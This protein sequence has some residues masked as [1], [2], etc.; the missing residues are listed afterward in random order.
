MKKHAIG[1]LSESVKAQIYGDKN[2]QSTSTTASSSSIYTTG[3]SSRAFT[4]TASVPQTAASADLK[5]LDELELR[6]SV[7]ALVRK[8]KMKGYVEMITNKGSFKVQLH[9][10]IAPV[11]CDNFLQLAESK[12]YDGVKFHRLIS[13]FMMQG[14]DPTGTGRGGKSAFNNGA[15]FKDEFDSRLTHDSMGVVSMANSGKRDDNKSQFFITFS[16]CEHLDNKHTVFGKLVGGISELMRLNTSATTGSDVPVDPI[17][18]ER[19]VVQENPFKSVV[20]SQKSEIDAEKKAKVD[21]IYVQA[22]RGDPMA[23]HANRSSLEI[24]KYIAWSSLGDGNRKKH[25]TATLG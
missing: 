1:S 7:H 11:T 9:C 18:I 6:R 19:I 22:A 21:A 14:G 5:P 3:Q 10:D 20:E 12:Y 8:A 15:P 24:G 16:A 13:N 2:S 23:H 25:K 4:S 17:Y